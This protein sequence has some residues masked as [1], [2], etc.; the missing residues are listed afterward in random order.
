MNPQIADVAASGT[1]QTDTAHI[2]DWNIDSGLTDG[3]GDAQRRGALG[4]S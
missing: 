3:D 2:G 1:I 4:N